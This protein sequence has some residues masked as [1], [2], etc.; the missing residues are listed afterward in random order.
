MKRAVSISIGSSKRNK[1]VE[2][3]LLGK[4][5]WLERIGTDGDMNQ[6]AALFKEL[7]GQVDA[8]GVGGAVL[9]LMV[10]ERWYNLPNVKSLVASVQKT[11]VVDGTGLKMTLECR[12]VNVVEELLK[13]SGQPRRVFFPSGVDR[14]GLA[15]SFIH[16]GYE[17]VIGDLMFTLGLPIPLHSIRS[18]ERLA[19][20][21]VPLL[22]HLPFEW[23]YPTGEAQEAHRPRWQKYFDWATLIAG[24]CHY[25]THAMPGSLEQ[26]II[27]TNTTTSED[28]QLFRQAGVRHLV[29]TTP[30]ID[31][32]SFGTNLIEAA[33]VAAMEYRQPIDYAHPAAY[34]A[35]MNRAI[36]ELHIQPE[37]VEL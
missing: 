30:V 34:L 25:I 24:D 16:A 17:S 20:M 31:G 9:G 36:D 21:L 19:A 4:K 23:L 28:R 14:F 29:T 37:L 15:S 22:G 10:G 8:L 33:L 3:E 6:A 2:I 5:V 35:M 18:L 12:A 27:V 1:A 11:P 7:D 32:R 13:D 26:K